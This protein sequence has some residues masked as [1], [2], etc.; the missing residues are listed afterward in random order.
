MSR[1]AVRMEDRLRA[2]RASQA[3][4]IGVVGVIVVLR[5]V[6][7]AVTAALFYTGDLRLYGLSQVVGTAFAAVLDI[8]LL[9]LVWTLFATLGRVERESERVQAFMD[10]VYGKLLQ[11]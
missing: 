9:F 4:I 10:N 1:L 8:I 5:L 7:Y 6:T 11:K 2:A 3:A